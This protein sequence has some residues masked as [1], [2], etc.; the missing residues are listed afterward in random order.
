MR[1]F[2]PRHNRPRRRAAESCD[3]LAPPHGHPS[4]RGALGYHRP[5]S[6]GHPRW[7]PNA[8]Q[9]V[10]RV[11][12]P[13]DH[14]K[15]IEDFGSPQRASVPTASLRPHPPRSGPFPSQGPK[16]LAARSRRDACTKLASVGRVFE[17]NFA[18]A[19]PA[20]VAGVI[21]A[22]LRLQQH[23]PCNGLA[24]PPRDRVMG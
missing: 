23:R 11:Y 13:S 5:T 22:N 7:S 15:R 21:F 12:W 3:E 14:T 4:R 16:S 20:S 6:D 2:R 9:L 17:L 1:S 18:V 24:S 8:R 10:S 19:Q